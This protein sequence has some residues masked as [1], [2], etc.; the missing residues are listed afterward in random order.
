MCWGILSPFHWMHYQRHPNQHTIKNLPTVHIYP[1]QALCLISPNINHPT[2]R[3]IHTPVASV[4]LVPKNVKHFTFLTPS[5]LSPAKNSLVNY[6][7]SAPILVKKT[8][9]AQTCSLCVNTLLHWR[10]SWQLHWSV[11]QKTSKR[12]VVVRRYKPSTLLYC[13]KRTLI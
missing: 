9:A 10:S 13:W 4:L 7:F 3:L 2:S 1:N 8:F 11:P 6:V 12:F 5:S